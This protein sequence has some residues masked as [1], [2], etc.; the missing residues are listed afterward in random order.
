MINH[1]PRER[2]LLVGLQLNRMP[3][4]NIGESMQE[5]EQLA[6][7]AGA[8]VVGEVVQVRK[9]P[10]AAFW[11]GKGKA[12]EIRDLCQG[13]EIDV[14]IF[15]DD[16]TPL[17]Q[18]NLEGIMGV[19]VI[20]RTQIIL[21]IFAQRARSGEGKIQVELAQLRYRLPRLTG[22]GVLLS[23]LGGGIG[24]RGPGETKLEIDRRQVRERINRLEKAL[25]EIC[26]HRALQRKRR[27]E[28]GLPTL[29][30]VGYTNAGKS[31]LLNALVDAHIAVQDQLFTT[32]DPTIRRVILPDHRQVLISDTVGFIRKLPYHLIAAFRATLEEVHLAD[33][34]L[35]VVDASH[36]FVEE[37]IAAVNQILKE[38]EVTSPIITVYNKCDLIPS[39][40]ID[41]LLRRSSMAVAI[42]ALRKWNLDQ[43]LEMVVTCLPDSRERLIFTIPYQKGEIIASLAR[44][45]SIINREYR[46]EGIVV[47]VNVSL[48]EKARIQE[49]LGSGDH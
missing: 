20:D 29:T 28:L 12:E 39:T 16:L 14:V 48:D 9:S 15:N 26:A 13:R 3:E 34:L 18:R 17:Q 19:K 21:D 36:P 37:Q 10:T 33:L 2:A 25:Q 31:T 27:R 45:G 42:S 8:E 6:L 30:L 1:G 4:E 41:N 7:T 23:Q 49:Y 38:L 44:Q 47:T 24:T 46:E 40:V 11:I 32:L 43:L 22:K 5:L 35:H